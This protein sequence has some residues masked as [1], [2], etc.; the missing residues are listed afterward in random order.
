MKKG[1]LIELTAQNLELYLEQFWTP[2]W[3]LSIRNSVCRSSS[4]ISRTH[5]MAF[6]APPSPTPY[7]VFVCI[8][9]RDNASDPLNH[10]GVKRIGPGSI[11]IFLKIYFSVCWCSKYSFPMRGTQGCEHHKL[12]ERNGVL[13]KKEK[14]LSENWWSITLEFYVAGNIASWKEHRF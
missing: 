2:D 4:F 10:L 3:S 8:I 5:S 1:S 11:I 6:P 7:R 13:R 9:L 12:W 14:C